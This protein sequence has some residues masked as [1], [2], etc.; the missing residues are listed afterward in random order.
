MVLRGAPPPSR[1]ELGRI[2]DRWSFVYFEHAVIHRSENAITATDSEGIVHV[3]AAVIA[4]LMLGPGTRI[5]NAAMALLGD[6]GVSVVWV[7][8]KGVRYYAHGRSIAKSSRMIELQARLVSNTRSRLAV[9]RAMYSYRFPGED[10]ADLTMQ[11][12]RG[13]E[14]ARIRRVY[15]AF[16][17]Q[18]GVPWKRRDY[19]VDDYEASD[20]INQALTAANSCLYGVVQAVVVSLGCSPA[21]GF[22]HSGTERSFIYDVADLYKAKISIPVAFQ[23]VATK[24]DD[25]SSEVR[26]AMRDRMVENDLISTCARDIK[27]LL[28]AGRVVEEPG[29]GLKLWAGTGNRY[30]PAGVNYT[31]DEDDSEVSLQDLRS[32]ASFV[33]WDELDHPGDLGSS[34]PKEREQSSSEEWK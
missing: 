18:T 5:S 9:T 26:R 32:S 33:S 25:V 4:C 3:P 15:R 8:E 2:E 21:L 13:R 24:P 7:G 16:S 11:Q 30:V 17:Q 27:A 20:P 29:A 1:Y 23:T 19:K 12:L 14:G 22:V 28:E 6:C 34:S 10:V 31:S